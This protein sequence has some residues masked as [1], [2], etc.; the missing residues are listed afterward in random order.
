MTSFERINCIENSTL[1]K[2]TNAEA[3]LLIN[4]TGFGWYRGDLKSRYNG[5]KRCSEDGVTFTF[6]CE[7]SRIEF[8]RLAPDGD[9]VDKWAARIFDKTR[10]C[11]SDM[12]MGII[13]CDFFR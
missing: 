3:Q 5:M 12:P 10:H 13:G 6:E 8:T 7:H 4:D 2:L 11:Y 9:N 1:A